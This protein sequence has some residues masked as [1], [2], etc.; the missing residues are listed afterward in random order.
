MDPTEREKKWNEMNWNWNEIYT[1]IY[2]YINGLASQIIRDKIP[3]LLC[4]KIHW[5]A[6][7]SPLFK[8]TI[9]AFHGSHEWESIAGWVV[10]IICIYIYIYMY[11][12]VRYWSRVGPRAAL[13]CIRRVGNP[14]RGPSSNLFNKKKL[15]FNLY[16]VKLLKIMNN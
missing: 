3:I 2:I 1:D 9:P 12:R 8:W 13:E 16:R 11:M 5:M 6:V 7:G 15:F 14:A 10:P 4:L